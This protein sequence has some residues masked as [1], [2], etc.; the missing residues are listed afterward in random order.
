M[1]DGQHYKVVKEDPKPEEIYVSRKNYANYFSN[2]NILFFD[3]EILQ[4]N[5]FFCYIS[6]E[7]S[8]N[9]IDGETNGLQK[10]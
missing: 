4:R 6:L 10:I 7:K 1:A 8:I 9:T 3:I 5:R 2:G